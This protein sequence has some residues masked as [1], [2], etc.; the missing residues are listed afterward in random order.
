MA[1]EKQT[2][3]GSCQHRR[4]L[5]KRLEI[6]ALPLR[7]GNTEHELADAKEVDHLRDAEERR[8]HHDATRAAFEERP[9]TFVPHR[10]PA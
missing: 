2:H 7:S 8:D 4:E 3:F 9:G 5:H 10:L 1:P 6:T